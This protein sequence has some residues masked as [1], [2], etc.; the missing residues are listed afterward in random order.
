MSYLEIP[1]KFKNPHNNILSNKILTILKY[2]CFNPGF[3]IKPIPINNLIGD[4]RDCN[5]LLIQ[6]KNRNQ[7]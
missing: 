6:N 5:D 3:D 4:L 7:Y 2:Y 1:L